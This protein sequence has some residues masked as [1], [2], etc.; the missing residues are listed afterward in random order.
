MAGRIA[1]AMAT[2]DQRA[3]EATERAHETRQ[4]LEEE[5]SGAI[6]RER[7]TQDAIERTVAVTQQAIERSQMV[8]Q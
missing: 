3:Q 8:E 5:R 1:L 2:A 4:V 6:E 7:S